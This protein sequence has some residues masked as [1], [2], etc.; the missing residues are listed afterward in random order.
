MKNVRSLGN[1]PPEPAGASP[2]KGFRVPSSE[3]AKI[4]RVEPRLKDKLVKFVGIFEGRQHTYH[5]EA[6]TEKSAAKLRELI[7]ENVGM[8][9]FEI[10]ALEL[11]DA[12]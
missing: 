3:E 4:V 10:G 7:G 12:A 5:Y 11:D 9:V 2:G 8:S 1:W 6:P